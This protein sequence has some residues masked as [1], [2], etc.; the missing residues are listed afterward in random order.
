MKIAVLSR[1]RNLYS[2]RRL[3]QTGIKRGHKM[4]VIDPLHCNLIMEKNQPQLYYGSKHKLDYVD[5]IIPRIGSSITFYGSAVIRQFEMMNVFSVT[6]SNALLRSRDKLRSMQLLSREGLDFPK[7]VYTNARTNVKEIIDSVGGVPLIVKSL[8]GTQGL[9]VML[10]ESKKAAVSVLEAFNSIKAETMVQE[11]IAEAG[12]ADIRAFV[13]DGKIVG[14]MKR[15]GVPGEF[16]SN[17]HRGGTANVIELTRKERS[18]AIKAA[19]TMGLAVAGVDMLQSK[20]GPLILEV[21]SSPGLEGIEAATNNDIA[22]DIIKYIERNVNSRKKR[23][24]AK[25]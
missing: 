17:L 4:I 15:Q 20:R 6:D 12:G 5:A 8:Q 1:N 9:G 10:L 3:V 11:F 2:T 14:A 7:T 19:E 16:R 18:H 25:G 22:S 13:V 21:N 24:R 23:K